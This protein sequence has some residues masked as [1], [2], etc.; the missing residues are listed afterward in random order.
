MDFLEGALLGRFWSD[1]DFETRR[2]KGFALLLS[3]LFWAVVLAGA[4]FI[5]FRT[6][7]FVMSRR[8]S[9][10]PFFIVLFLATPVIGYYYYKLPLIPR[11]GALGLLV[12]KYLSLFM[13]I[14]TAV[15]P[16]L[17][18][19]DDL[20]LNEILAFF[21]ATVGNYIETQTE[22]FGWNGLLLSGI[23]SAL[24][25]GI[26]FLVIIY[27]MIKLP[28]WTYKFVTWIQRIYDETIFMSIKNRKQQPRKPR[29]NMSKNSLFKRRRP[30]ASFDGNT[31]T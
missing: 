22:S 25:A 10:L 16:Q 2:H 9:W 11:F 26:G 30:T 7:P 27:V 21:E 29:S 14:I 28:Q 12:L 17:R 13:T 19:P 23:V 5:N 1:T 15:I 20:S 8:M 6:L 31:E 3:T 24:V 4:Y 18:I